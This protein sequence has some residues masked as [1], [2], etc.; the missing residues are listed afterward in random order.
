MEERLGIA[1]SG[2]IACGLA[3]TAAQHGDVVLWARSERSAERARGA[4]AKWCGKLSEEPI[5]ERVTVVS[6]L[7]ELAS[8][9]FLVEAVAEDHGVKAGVLSELGRISGDD[10]VLATTTSS[11]SVTALAQESGRPERFVGL[12]VFN[13]VPKMA[14]VELAYAPAAVEAV[15]ERAR[16]LCATLGKTAVEVPDIAGFVVN[17]LLFPYLFSAVELLE[18][19][20]MPPAAID[21]CMQLGA[22]HPMGPLALLDYVGLDVSKAIG[23]AIGAPVPARVEAL[24]AAGDLGKK[25]GRGFHDYT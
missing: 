21:Q 16:V 12:H 9:T 14:L 1:G 2:A 25:S 24:V 10:A 17:R 19:T 6:D 15:R 20:G 13:P 3:A 5:A 7:S 11:L 22:G 4:V 18:Q 23:E 8:A